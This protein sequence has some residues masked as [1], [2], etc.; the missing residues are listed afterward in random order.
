MAKFNI[1]DKVTAWDED[2][3]IVKGVN[4]NTD[5]PEYWLEDDNGTRMTYG[6]DILSLYADPFDPQPGQCYEGPEGYEDVYVVTRFKT[7]SGND[8]VAYEWRYDNPVRAYASA[9]PVED[10]QADYP[11]LK[12][13]KFGGLKVGDKRQKTNGR[14][15]ALVANLY[16]RDGQER[17]TYHFGTPDGME[18]RFDHYNQDRT[19]KDFLETEKYIV[20]GWH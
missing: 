12:A 11:T 17:V 3:L 5:P 6:E 7:S 13:V 8:Y 2:A 14:L 19:V 20:E 15:A 10:F 16:E 4:E 9:M 1:D 18:N